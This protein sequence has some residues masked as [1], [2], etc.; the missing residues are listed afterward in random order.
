MPVVPNSTKQKQQQY[1]LGHGKLEEITWTNKHVKT[2]G[3]YHG[4]QIWM[5]KIA[6]IKNCIQV[7]KSRNLTL[8]GKVLIIKTF[9]ISQIGFEIEMKNIPKNVEKEI[10]TLLWDYLWEGKQ[11]LVNRQTMCLNFELGA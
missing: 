3:V 11:P 4:Y 9:L 8:R 2:F 6:K 1:I 7:W 5:G 10:N